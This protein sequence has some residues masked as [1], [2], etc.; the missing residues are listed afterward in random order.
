MG[1][2]VWGLG[3]KS[4]ARRSFKTGRTFTGTG[5]RAVPDLGNRDFRPRAPPNCVFLDWRRFWIATQAGLEITRV[6]P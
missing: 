5:V 4:V 1:R 2:R 6:V 3:I